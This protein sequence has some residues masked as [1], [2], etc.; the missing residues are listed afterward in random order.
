M[1]SLLPLRLAARV[2][3]L[4]P[5][6]RVLLLRYDDPPPN[7]VHWVTP[8]G[9]LDAGEEPPHAALREL[10]EETGWTDVALGRELGHGERVL[11]HSG[12]L[13]RQCEVHYMARVDVARR[14]V[15]TAGHAADKISAWRWWTPA[16]LTATNERLLPAHLVELVDRAAACCRRPSRAAV[17]CWASGRPNFPRPDRWMP[18]QGV[19]RC[20]AKV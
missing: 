17:S 3:V 9:G 10:A 2:V 19:P 6:G 11:E 20:D 4:D 12:R 8:G 14:A 18:P 13:V 16:E 7:G 15:G 1:A 5:A